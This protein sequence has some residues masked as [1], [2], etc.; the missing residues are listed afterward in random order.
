MWIRNTE[1]NHGNMCVNCT[2]SARERS[3]QA[4]H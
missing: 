3:R 2:F 1:A 4:R